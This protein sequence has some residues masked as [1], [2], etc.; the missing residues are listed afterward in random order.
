MKRYYVECTPI[1]RGLT[2][3]EYLAQYI[4]E[5]FPTAKFYPLFDNGLIQFGYIEGND[6]TLCNVL[7]FCEKIFAMNR[8]LIEEFRG[9]AQL[10]W[11]SSVPIMGMD[12]TAQTIAEFFISNNI[13]PTSNI[14]N[15]VKAYKVKLLKEK[16]KR[17]FSD[18]N[19]LVANMAKEV[20][21]LAEYKPTLDAGQLVRLNNALAIMKSIYTAET[22]LT[23]LEEDI[24]ILSN[25]MPSYY[26]TKISIAN[27]TTIEQLNSIDIIGS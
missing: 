20:L 2:G 25:F 16:V 8:L 23:S 7:S 27:A 19:D 24:A 26:N 13:E 11:T 1:R 4:D 15:D 3:R 10:Y 22:C 12:G 21:L 14:L 18:Y 6:E 5:S 17:D 9:A